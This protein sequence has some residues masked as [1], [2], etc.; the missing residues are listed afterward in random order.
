MLSC[1]E[2]NGVHVRFSLF[3]DKPSP[4]EEGEILIIKPFLHF[5]AWFTPYATTFAISFSA[6]TG[7]QVPASYS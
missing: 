4:I 7:P 2:S 6:A 5:A 3:G 1:W